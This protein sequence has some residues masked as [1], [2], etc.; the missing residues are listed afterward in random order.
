[1]SIDILLERARST[2]EGALTRT[3]RSADQERGPVSTVHN[4]RDRV[5]TLDKSS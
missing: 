3:G 1:M 5:L 4:S 2:T